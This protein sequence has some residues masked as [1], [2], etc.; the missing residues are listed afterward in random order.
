MAFVPI[1]LEDYV[2]LHVRSNPGENAADATARLQFALNIQSQ[3]PLS[4]WRTNLGD[5]IGGGGTHVLQLYYRRIRFLRG[6][7]NS[8]G[9]R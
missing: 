2:R 3:T 5:R 4:L 9:M 7:R 1:Q 6:L 8:R